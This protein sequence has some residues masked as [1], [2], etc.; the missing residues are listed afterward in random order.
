MGVLR[1]VSGVYGGRFIKAP[2]GGQTR[3][4]AQFVREALFGIIAPLVAGATFA[5]VFAGSGAIG[6]EAL[7]RG[8]ARA[9]FAD[10]SRGCA[11]LIRENL[12]RLGI[13]EREAV[14]VRVDMASDSAPGMLADGLSRLGAAAA[15]II[16]ADPPYGYADIGALP[17]ILSAPRILAPSGVLIL[18]H[19]KKAAPPQSA[20]I[21]EKYDERKYGDTRLSFYRK[22]T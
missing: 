13:S 3:P 18:E 10:R 6:V 16:Y 9:L 12:G 15:D 22:I 7:S 4:T 21:L 19:G 11:G 2:D 20:G 5:D 8:A 17:L 14:T 1:I